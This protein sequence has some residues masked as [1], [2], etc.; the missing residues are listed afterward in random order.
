MAALPCFISTSS[1]QDDDDWVHG[2]ALS[3]FPQTSQGSNGVQLQLSCYLENLYL[4]SDQIKNF[5]FQSLAV[6]GVIFFCRLEVSLILAL[7]LQVDIFHHVQ[8]TF[9][10]SSFMY[11]LPFLRQQSVVQWVLYLQVLESFHEESV[12]PEETLSLLKCPT[13]SSSESIPFN[14]LLYRLGLH[15]S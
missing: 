7:T 13:A 5:C 2:A 11:C 9:C 6:V 4:I 8:V 3:Y 1:S 10:Q 12:C 14:S 15:V